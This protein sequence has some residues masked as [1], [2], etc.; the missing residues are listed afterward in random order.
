M[1]LL[2]LVGIAAVAV[3]LSAKASAKQLPAADDHGLIRADEGD[4]VFFVLNFE[5]EP[6]ELE[7][8]ED[9]DFS[10][11]MAQNGFD[12]LEWK[13]LRRSLTTVLVIAEVNRDLQVKLDQWFRLHEALP[14]R[15]RFT[16][17]VAYT[18]DTQREFDANPSV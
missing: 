17:F 16:R 7:V 13:Q 15:A 4:R 6:S 14:E 8:F 5:S 3:A 1:W 10:L 11:I 2:A 12:V 18:A 9:D